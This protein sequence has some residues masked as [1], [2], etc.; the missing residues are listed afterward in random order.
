M[1]SIVAKSRRLGKPNK[2]VSILP[3]GRRQ[4]VLCITHHAPSSSP[5]VL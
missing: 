1:P 4:I 2:F 3:N 5:L